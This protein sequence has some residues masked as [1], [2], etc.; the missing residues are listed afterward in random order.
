[1]VRRTWTL[2]FGAALAGTMTFIPTFRH[3]R[4]YNVISLTGTAYSALYLI[5][6]ATS[7]LAPVPCSVPAAP[8]CVLQQIAAVL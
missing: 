5:I 6:T 8:G 4:I 7:K 1:M 3:F 2:I